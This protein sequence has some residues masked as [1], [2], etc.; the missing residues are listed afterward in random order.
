MLIKIFR[1]T[2]TDFRFVRIPRGESVFQLLSK[3]K[4]EQI[5]YE[6]CL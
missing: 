4:K 6:T 2:I 3:K 5:S 1:C